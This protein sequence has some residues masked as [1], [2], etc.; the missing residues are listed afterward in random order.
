MRRYGSTAIS[1]ELLTELLHAHVA[2]DAHGCVADD[3]RDG[4]ILPTAY[5]SSVKQLDVTVGVDGELEV[6]WEAVVRSA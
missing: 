2:Q 4:T 6:E 5:L 1:R 3:V